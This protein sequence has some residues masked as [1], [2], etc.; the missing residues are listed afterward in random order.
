MQKPT[1][2]GLQ[3]GV[4]CSTRQHNVKHK[5]YQRSECTVWAARRALTPSLQCRS[6]NGMHTGRLEANRTW[7]P[8]RAPRSKQLKLTC[9]PAAEQH[10]DGLSKPKVV[11]LGS[12]GLDYL[13]QVAAFP[14]PDEKLRTSKMEVGEPDFVH[15]QC[16]ISIV[17]YCRVS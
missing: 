12:I 2:T 5:S 13:A 1:T 3:R 16:I 14:K 17:P 6:L 7:R 4:P 11:G 8:A 9:R 15:N 10:V